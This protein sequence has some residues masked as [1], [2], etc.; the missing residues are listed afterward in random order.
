M[1]PDQV[2]AGIDNKAIETLDR[3][4]CK[5]TVLEA[6]GTIG[7]TKQQALRMLVIL[8]FFSAAPALNTISG[9]DLHR[10]RAIGKD[11]FRGGGPFPEE[12][13]ATRIGINS[14]CLTEK[15]ASS[16]DH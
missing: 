2:Q 9:I 13:S 4:I 1:G 3:R 5:D 8:V 14:V 6:A 12:A 11:E 7:A 16:H 10:G 15:I